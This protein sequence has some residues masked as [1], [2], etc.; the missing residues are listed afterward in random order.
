MTEN[1][2]SIRGRGR[3]KFDQAHKQAADRFQQACGKIS[4]SKTVSLPLWRQLAE[5]LEAVIRAGELEPHSRMP[6]EEALKEMFGVSRTVVRN[7]MQTL[8]NRG[9]VV[10]VHRKGIFVDAPPLETA[11]LTSNLSVYDDMV[12]RGHQVS[13]NTFEFQRAEAEQEERDALQL[14]DDET[15]IRI[16]RLFWMDEKPITYTHMTLHGGKLPG[17]ETLNIENRSILGLI[18]ER[19]GRRLRRCERWFRAVIAPDYVCEAMGVAPGTPM[20]WIESIAYEADNT[21]LEF[22]R[23]YYNSDAASMHLSIVD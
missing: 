20:M 14:K 2:V 7:A 3:P 18:R 13:T 16:G 22:Y 11:F 9:L 8:A 10:K 5:Q 1:V 17:F 12:S 21:P 4:V 19:Y 23:A 6:S 15:V